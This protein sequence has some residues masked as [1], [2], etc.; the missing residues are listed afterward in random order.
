[1]E[2]IKEEDI[3]KQYIKSG[4]IMYNSIFT[5]DY[6]KSNKENAKII[7]IFKYLENNISIAKRVLPKLFDNKNVQVKTEAASESLAL[8]IYEEEAEKIL[9]EI[10][11]SKENGIFAFNA[12][13]I[14]K[15]WKKNGKLEIYQ[16]NK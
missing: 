15:V 6:K 2:E 4:E 7:K 14:L 5:G 3:I 1:M 10:A 8:K 11:N 12:N 9:K 16:K 13:M